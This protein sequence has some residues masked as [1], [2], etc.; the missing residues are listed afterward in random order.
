MARTKVPP[1]VGKIG[2]KSPRYPPGQWPKDA[3]NVGSRKGKAANKARGKSYKVK[4]NKFKVAKT[5][6]KSYRNR[7]G[8]VALREIRKFQKSTDLLLRK[9]PFQRVVREVSQEYMQDV[10]FTAGALLALQEATEAYMVKKF[11]AANLLAIHAKRVT[12]LEKDMKLTTRFEEL[13]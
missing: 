2:K 4:G 6:N 5:V 12:V 8:I 11:E 3:E 10:R 13:Y 9:L 7:P 1:K